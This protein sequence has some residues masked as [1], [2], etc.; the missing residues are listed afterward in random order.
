MRLTLAYALS[1]T[2][3]LNARTSPTLAWNCRRM[4]VNSL[5]PALPTTVPTGRQ[6]WAPLVWSLVAVTGVLIYFTCSLV[7]GAI[8]AP[9]RIGVIVVYQRVWRRLDRACA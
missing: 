2:S 6:D 5:V 8:L 3:M 9:N 1:G 4:N 7:G